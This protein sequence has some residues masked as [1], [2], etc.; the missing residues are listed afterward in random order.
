[1]NMTK[2]HH[3]AVA[4]TLFVSVVLAG[5]TGG[6]TKIGADES[7]TVAWVD[8]S[9]TITVRN[10][11]DGLAWDPLPFPT[12]VKSSTGPG[13]AADPMGIMHLI[14]T[15]VPS[16]NTVGVFGLG[17]QAYTLTKP[18]T[19]ATASQISMHSAPALASTDNDTWYVTYREQ[20]SAKLTLLKRIAVSGGPG[21]TNTWS[22]ET[23]S[24]GVNNT[25]VV[26]RPSLAIVGTRVVLTWHRQAQPPELQVVVGDAAANGSITWLGGY[27]FP[28]THT[29][30]G[31]VEPAHDLTQDGKQFVLGV[32]RE[33][34]PPSP[35]LKHYSLYVYHSADGKKWQLK[36]VLGTKSAGKSMHYESPLGLATKSNGQ[37]MVA[38]S[39]AGLLRAFRYD[40]SKWDDISN[41]F[42]TAYPA[43]GK[44]VAVVNTGRP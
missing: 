33:D 12:S 25:S 36:T 11:K 1:M 27:V 41:L 29:G 37:M 42:P 40:G 26:G 16:G 38:Q 15:N 7:Y 10:S 35:P 4:L 34:L 23:P 3:I 22:D 39:A 9:D 30:A 6:S 28:H 43:K 17:P 2:P 14:M 19:L 8:S 13:I 20:Q 18:D 21:F 44:H 5:C 31:G 24:L 32:V